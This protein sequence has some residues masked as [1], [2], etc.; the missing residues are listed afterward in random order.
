MED[1]FEATFVV[2]LPIDAVWEALARGEQPDGRFWLPGFEAPGERLEVEPARLLRVRKAAEPCA[3]TE[4]AIQLEASGSGTRVH[5]V[6]S[7]FPA[8][9]RAARELFQ[10]GWSQIVA[11]LILYLERGVSARRHVS[12]WAHPGCGVR[13]VPT[14]LEVTAVL[15]GGFAAQAGL[16]PGDRLLYLGGAPVFSQLELQ[17]LLRVFRRG[18]ELEASFVRGRELRSGSGVL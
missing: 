8:A 12:P 17:A 10:I 9:M 4:I 13:E 5:V 6:Q 18:D 2:E 16:L 1:R 14:G 7:G 15:P 11:D 3:G